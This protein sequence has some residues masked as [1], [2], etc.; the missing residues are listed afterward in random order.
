MI[1]GGLGGVLGL[2]FGFLIFLVGHLL[3][4]VLALIS[5]GLHGLRLQ[6]V[7]FMTKFF[8]GGGDPYQPLRAKRQLTR[9]IET[10]V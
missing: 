4:W 6:Y 10:E 1:A 2:V 7:E 9:A 5:C 8:V 3:V